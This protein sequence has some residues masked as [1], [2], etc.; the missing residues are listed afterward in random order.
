[1]LPWGHR[2]VLSRT[3]FVSR[4]RKAA[5]RV[6]RRRGLLRKKNGGGIFRRRKKMKISMPQPRLLTDFENIMKLK[7]VG[8]PKPK[9]FG[10]KHEKRKKQMFDKRKEYFYNELLTLN[11]YTERT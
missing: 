9:S 5:R 7:I 1:L 2:N 11:I 6:L 8:S 10:N 4:V 3:L